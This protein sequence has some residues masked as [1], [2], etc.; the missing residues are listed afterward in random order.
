V[1]FRL[2]RNHSS[3]LQGGT[4]LECAER[5][6]LLERETT[7]PEALLESLGSNRLLVLRR[8]LRALGLR[9]SGSSLECASRLLLV[10]TVLVETLDTNHS[11]HYNE[12]DMPPL[13]CI[14]DC[15]DVQTAQVS[16]RNMQ[17]NQQFVR[18]ALFGL[19]ALAALS[20]A[21]LMLV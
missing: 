16:M 12:D 18:V 11:D 14:C 19:T 2:Q 1:K 21:Y 4:A 13:E 9:D 3:A 15:D 10:L 20:C 5:L 7:Q 17:G 8:R 6:L